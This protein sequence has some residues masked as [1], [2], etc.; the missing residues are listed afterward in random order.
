[1][2]NIVLVEFKQSSNRVLTEFS[3]FPAV[4]RVGEHCSNAGDGGVCG[5][6][7][8]YCD[9]EKEEC[10]CRSGTVPQWGGERCGEE[11]S[12]VAGETCS[13]ERGIGECS[14]DSI[15]SSSQTSPYW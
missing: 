4:K 8:A 6:E 14:D 1:M 12:R 7:G 9:E 13:P 10:R 15:C 11:G 5:A 3:F 2:S